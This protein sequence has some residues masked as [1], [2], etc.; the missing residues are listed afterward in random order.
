MV[1]HNMPKCGPGPIQAHSYGPFIVGSGARPLAT[2]Y[3]FRAPRWPAGAPSPPS[4]ASPGPPGTLPKALAGP[5]APRRR[6]SAAL[7]AAAVEGVVGQP[8][9]RRGEGPDGPGPTAP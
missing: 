7:P 2:L 3:G 5:A 8:D 1:V 4:R 6:P 9:Q